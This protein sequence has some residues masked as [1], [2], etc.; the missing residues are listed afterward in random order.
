MSLVFKFWKEHI[1]IYRTDSL[2]V[3]DGSYEIPLGGSNFEYVS[4]TYFVEVTGYV[5]YSQSL[6]YTY[7]SRSLVCVS[8]LK[9]LG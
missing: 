9:I 4:V 7:R 2:I 5:T 3:G 6:V 1:C 8:C